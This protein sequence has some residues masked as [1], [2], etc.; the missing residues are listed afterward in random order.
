MA[1][2]WAEPFLGAICLDVCCGSGDITRLL[3]RRVGSS[4]RVTG[5]DFAANQ[6]AIARQHTQYVPNAAPIDWIEGDALHLPFASDQFDVVTMGYGLRNVV[7]ISRS[8][9]EL[10]RVLKPGGRLAILD[11]HSPNNS[12]LK[13]FQQWY[14]HTIVVPI[15][16]D[17]GLEQEY[18]YIRPSLARFPNGNQQVQMSQ[19]VGFSTSTHYAIAGGMMGILVAKKS[20]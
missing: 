10:Y 19:Q 17:F 5:L 15:A 3:A 14:L 7:D 6:L 18:A 1:V 9:C 8:L 4:G 16:R 11:M 20:G 2:K 12:W 13:Q